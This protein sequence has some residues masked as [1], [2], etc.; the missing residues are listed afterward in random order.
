MSNQQETKLREILTDQQVV[1]RAN[2]DP[3]RLYVKYR[4]YFFYD[5]EIVQF[6]SHTTRCSE[7]KAMFRNL[8][9]ITQFNAN[10]YRVCF[11]RK[12]PYLT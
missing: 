11:N 7:K 6:F 4:I 3:K 8:W 10:R 12:I 2:W 1:N 9:N 5:K